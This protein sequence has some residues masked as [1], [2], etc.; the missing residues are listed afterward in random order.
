MSKPPVVCDNGTGFV[1]CGFAGDNLPRAVFPCMVGRPML[2]AAAQA[3][4]GQS[5]G[6]QTALKDLTVGAEAAR[7]R[8]SLEVSYPI[9]EGVV[10]SWDDMKHVWRHTFE[11][12]LKVDPSECRIMLTDPP[13]NPK[14]NRE[15]LIETMFEEFGFAGAFIQIQ[16]VLTLYARGLMTGL[17]LDSGDGVTHIIPVVDGYGFSHLTKRLNVA[18]RHV[19]EHLVDLLLRRGYAFN[20]TADFDTVRQIKEQLCYVSHDYAQEMRIADETTCLV[21][22]FTLPDGRTIKLGAERFQA[23]EVLFSPELMGV[24]G[25]GMADLVFKCISEMEIDNRMKLYEHVVLSGG[26]TMYAGLPSRLERDIKKLYL[27]HVLQGNTAGLKKLKLRV[28]DPPNRKHMV[29]L[30]AAVLANIMKAHDEFWISKQE[31]EEEGVN[32]L[33]RKCGS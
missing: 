18:G 19:T 14:R 25:G 26:S 3:A 6:G 2:R 12:V 30:G 4:D 27:E 7:L 31:W 33:H 22:Q 10:Q 8:H 28:E 16:A 1:K 32:A 5:P 21:Q 11:E 29:F 24:E 20:R 17:V 23:P 15:K 13:M 9:R